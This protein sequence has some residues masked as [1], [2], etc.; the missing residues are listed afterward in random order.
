MLI[1]LKKWLKAMIKLKPI[2]DSI[3][4]IL[5]I[6]RATT[7]PEGCLNSNDTKLKFKIKPNK[8]SSNDII[9]IRKLFLFI[10]R[11]N[12][13]IVIKIVERNSPCVII[14]L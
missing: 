14:F 6:K 5:I 2:A 12:N 10:S 1:V 11:P 3:A 13:P 9:T 8:A 7:W 4:A